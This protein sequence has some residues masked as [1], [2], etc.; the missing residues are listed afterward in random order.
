MAFILSRIIKYYREEDIKLDGNP[1]NKWQI[2][3]IRDKFG[4]FNDEYIL[5][6]YFGLEPI[7]NKIFYID[8]MYRD[9]KMISDF[10]KQAS[11]RIY[12]L[13]IIASRILD[14]TYT[15]NEGPKVVISLEIEPILEK[16][17]EFLRTFPYLKDEPEETI[18]R[19]MKNNFAFSRLLGIA[20]CRLTDKKVIE[21]KIA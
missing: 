1:L 16:R 15:Y 12:N 4:N 14:N 11:N 13:S 10:F 20:I 8:E 2:E 3:D 6:N 5:F 9:K 18:I 21:E 7:E 17:D 19:Y